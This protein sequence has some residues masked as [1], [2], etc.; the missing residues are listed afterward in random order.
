MFSFFPFENGERSV[1][2]LSWERRVIDAVL[3]E[4]APNCCYEH[5]PKVGAQGNCIGDANIDR[6]KDKKSGYDRASVGAEIW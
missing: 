2:L 5:R 3:F 1:K 4:G 6:K